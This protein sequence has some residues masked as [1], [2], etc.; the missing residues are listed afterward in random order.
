[1]LEV[2]WGDVTSARAPGWL[3]GNK[4]S[5]LF[6]FPPISAPS[7]VPVPCHLFPVS[8]SL[9][10]ASCRWETP[11]WSFVKGGE[12]YGCGVADF[13]PLLGCENHFS[14]DWHRRASPPSPP[15]HPWKS[16]LEVFFT[17]PPAAWPSV[18]CPFSV[19]S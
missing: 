12:G 16:F 2:A 9:A 11:A 5:S 15:L 8:L 19:L 1:M 14:L 10:L 4:A 13:A 17:F 3:P 7:P 6:H 18:I